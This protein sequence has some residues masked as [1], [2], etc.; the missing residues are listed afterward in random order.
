[1]SLPFLIV[2]LTGFNPNSSL[3]CAFFGIKIHPLDHAHFSSVQLYL[4]FHLLMY[5]C[6]FF[7]QALHICCL[8]VL[9]KQVSIK[10]RTWTCDFFAITA[11]SQF[12]SCTMYFKCFIRKLIILP[13]GCSSSSRVFDSSVQCDTNLFQYDQILFAKCLVFQNW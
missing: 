1:M 8:S 2:G 10:L 11:E 3:S 9:M 12:S 5:I 13:V 7:S 6:K 4:M